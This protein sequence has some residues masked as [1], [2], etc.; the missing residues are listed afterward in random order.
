[1]KLT[2]R[3]LDGMAFESELGGHKIVVDA[4]REVGGSDR[5]PSPKPL[6]LVALAGC[7]GMDVISIL[8]KMR[9]NVES[10]EVRTL[11][12][13]ARE[14]PKKY[15]AVRV[16]YVLNGP[17]LDSDKVSKAVSLSEERYCGVFA[18]LRPGVEMTRTIIL[19]GDELD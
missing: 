14:H 4:H 15:T 17:N 13:E 19:N 9:Q 7:T 8:R 10:F 3:W 18:T 1:M 2:T 16:T 6:L 11:A 12:E 5:G